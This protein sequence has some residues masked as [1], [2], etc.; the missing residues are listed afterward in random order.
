M[1]KILSLV[2]LV[3]VV[4][5]GTA[6]PKKTVIEATR[7]LPRDAAF[8]VKRNVACS[9]W[10][11]QMPDDPMDEDVQKTGRPQMVNSQ[12]KKFNCTSLDGDEIKVREKYK[13]N[14]DILASMDKSEKLPYAKEDDF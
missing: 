11:R 3:V 13:G 5:C 6:D 8:V 7:D 4:G 14:S 12:L 9:Y 2:L 10:K 1:R